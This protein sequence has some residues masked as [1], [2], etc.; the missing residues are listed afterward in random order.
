MLENVYEGLNAQKCIWRLKCSTQVYLSKE[1]FCE[2]YPT[3]VSSK[4]CE[5]IPSDTLI[6]GISRDGSKNENIRTC[7]HMIQGQ[8]RMGALATIYA[9]LRFDIVMT[10]ISPS[11]FLEKPGCK[12]TIVSS[13]HFTAGVFRPSDESYAKGD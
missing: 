4:L 11:V 7:E 12:I 2:I 1:Y 3:C 9:A 10:F 13:R 5:F 6:F 8:L